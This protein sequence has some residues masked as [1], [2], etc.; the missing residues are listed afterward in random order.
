ML[1][2]YSIIVHNLKVPKFF[3]FTSQC[4]YGGICNSAA[5]NLINFI[6]RFFAD[7]HVILVFARISMQCRKSTIQG[8]Q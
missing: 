4:T 1:I 5:N 8:V 3:P 6:D 2:H 7:L